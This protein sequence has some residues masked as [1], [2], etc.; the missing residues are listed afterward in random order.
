M[1]AGFTN[2]NA[3]IVVV[4][5][6]SFG[7]ILQ[8]WSKSCST[9]NPCIAEALAIAWALQLA[10]LE[11]FLDIQVE[12]DAQVCI[13][14]INGHTADIPWKILQVI[15]NVKVLAALFK[16]CSF[17]WVRRS[18][19]SVAHSLAKEASASP[20]CFHCNNSNLPPSVH[21]AF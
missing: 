7:T 2:D 12:G 18:A 21:E 10:R 17:V 19:N 16:S 13:N 15:S 4:A 9:T 14:A 11:K 8:C 6:D 3:S 1:D 5:R 20:S